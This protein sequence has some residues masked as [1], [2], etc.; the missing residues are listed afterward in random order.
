MTMRMLCAGILVAVL[1]CAGGASPPPEPPLPTSRSE[2]ARALIDA[3]VV[4]ASVAGV[5]DGFRRLAIERARANVEAL[6]T[7]L[8]SVAPERREVIRR[9]LDEMPAR[10]EEDLEAFLGSIDFDDLARDLYTPLYSERFEVAELQ[11]ILRFYRSPAGQAFARENAEIVRIGTAEL[12]GR[13]EP[14]LAAFMREWFE[15]RLRGLQSEI[16]P[17]LEGG[18]SPSPG[19]GDGP[20]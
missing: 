11:A 19:P 16:D 4:R 20:G 5:V 7:R 15:T 13:L 6:E 18:R 9:R 14:T 12:A 8:E 2:L 1:G 3:G 10:F 17:G